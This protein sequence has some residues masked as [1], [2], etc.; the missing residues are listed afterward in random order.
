MINMIASSQEF[1]AHPCVLSRMRSAAILCVA[2]VIVFL[3]SEA[4]AQSGK[5][6]TA[7][8]TVW[9]TCALP[10][11][12]LDYTAFTHVVH[13]G[14]EPDAAYTSTTTDGLPIKYWRLPEPAEGWS[15]QAY[16]EQGVGTGCDASPIQADLIRLAHAKGAKV[17][18]GLGGSWGNADQMAKVAADSVK[19]RQYVSSI[20]NYARKR[21]YD[22]VDMDWEFVYSDERNL[23]KVLMQALYDSLQRWTPKGLLTIAIPG[24][25]DPGYGYDYPTMNRLCDQINMMNYD[26]YAPTW[27]T[28][29]YHHAALYA[30]SCGVSGTEN[31]DQGVKDVIAAGATPSKLGV[32]IP[33]YGY[34]TYF[35][36]GPCQTLKQQ[37]WSGQISYYEALEMKTAKNFHWDDAGRVPW[38]G[39]SDSMGFV[40]Y[41]DERSVAEKAKYAIAKGLGGV[42]VFELWRGLV[43]TNPTSQQQP[44]MAAVKAAMATAPN[45]TEPQAPVPQEYSLAQN[46]PNPFNPRTLIEYTV[47][48][49][50]TQ[51]LGASNVELVV[52]DVLGR[53]IETLVNEPKAPGRYTFEFDASGL[54]S[55]VYVYRLKAG[56]YVTSKKM[57]L[58]R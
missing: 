24:W 55:G 48:G 14:I 15:G 1:H 56:E 36:N 49:T 20:L 29:T 5:W 6:T 18:L 39:R 45:A 17:I 27:S 28:T 10:P 30:M 35:N 21:G 16:F 54:A 32:G 3:I 47:G 9:G 4:N 7:Y 42:M 51:G 8:Y 33:F 46:Y 22:G 53:E 13:Q 58:T 25:T 52:Y 41:D 12:D 44:L 11:S 2:V 40:C 26:M 43:S 37:G 38:L 23:F 19:R 34:E 57:V 50:R 31:V